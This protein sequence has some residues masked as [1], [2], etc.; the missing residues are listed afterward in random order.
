[1]FMIIILII[2]QML[3][4]Y[5]SYFPIAKHYTGKILGIVIKS[6]KP[7]M[8]PKTKILWNCSKTA[9]KLILRVSKDQD[10][11]SMLMYALNPSTGK[12][13]IGEIEA[14]MVYTMSSKIS[15]AI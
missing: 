13:D 12:A 9:T 10:K 14:R 11:P 7:A 1:M 3:N 8:Q 6:L 15:R 2:A 5:Y 4:I